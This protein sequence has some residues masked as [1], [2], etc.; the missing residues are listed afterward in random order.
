MNGM[1]MNGDQLYVATDHG[2]WV[3]HVKTGEK[4]H[5]EDIRL[6]GGR[7]LKIDCQTIAFDKQGGLWLG[8]ENRGVL[9][10]SPSTSPFIIYDAEAN[11][12]KQYIEMM[13]GLKQNIHEFNGM[14]ANCLYKDSRGWSWIGTTSGLYLYRS[15]KDEPEVFSR[16]N[17]LLNDVIHAVV[18][19]NDKNMWVSTSYGISFIMLDQDKVVFVNNFNQADNVPN[20]MFMNCKAMRLDNGHIV[21]QGIDHVIEFEPARFR[22]VNNR[23]SGKMYPKMIKLTVNGN[24]VEPMQELDGNV[25][26]DKAITRVRDIY[27][28]ADQNTIALTFSGLNYFRPLQTYYRVRVK[29]LD[30]DWH[31]YS[32]FNGTGLVD[33]KGQ[34]RLPLVGLKPGEY[35]V[36]V[37]S[38][39]YPDVWEDEEP[40][41]WIIYVN[42]PWWQR[43][44]VYCVIITLILILL[45]VNFVF[46]NKN[47]RMRVRRNAEEGDMIRKIKSFIDRC[48]AFDSEIL[49]PDEEELYGSR[50]EKDNSKLSPQF[51]ELMIKII[52]FVHSQK[53]LVTMRQL[54]EAGNIDIV[55]FYD[56]MTTN[57]YKN[58]NELI[59]TF[60]IEKAAGLLTTTQQTIEEIAST[61][62][63]YTPNYF[64]GSF[65]HR[66]KM[67]PREYREEHQK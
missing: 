21:M 41:R 45:V 23:L 36:E 64:L 65:F 58:P 3:Y 43:S 11:Q 40:Y 62:G 24:N 61:C 63:F 44:G 25:V 28:N 66:Y 51:V 59:K 5:V 19:D 6:V 52:P 4:T 2:Y 32:Y 18:E 35:Q 12:A 53:G 22:L 13:D 16:E 60:R 56:I 47:T 42:Q 20:E 27:L 37:Q 10:S 8:T 15:P 29:G 7:L 48:D 9:Y 49:Q 38:S 55:D 46:Y 33:D 57:L 67:T 1:A 17:G 30:N 39:M 34:L 14:H 31:V 50:L 54:S 26:I